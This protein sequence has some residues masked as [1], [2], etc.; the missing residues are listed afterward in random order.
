MEEPRPL[1]TFPPPDKRRRLT[2]PAA[3]AAPQPGP[4]PAAKAADLAIASVLAK[5]DPTRLATT[6]R[7]LAGFNTRHS[8]CPHNVAA[9]KW[10]RDRFL[11]I[12]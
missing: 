3:K 10:L 6:V 7:A 2:D 9:A 11:A 12:G 5:V 8:L 1:P 4:A